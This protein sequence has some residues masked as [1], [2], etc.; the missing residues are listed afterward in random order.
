VAIVSER[1]S[2]VDRMIRILERVEYRRAESDGDKAAIFRMRHEAYTRD[3]KVAASPSRMFHD[4][5]DLS[6][7]AWL[8]GVFIDGELASSIR[9]HVSASLSAPLPA[10]AVF[11]DV[12]APH[13]SEGHC[14][15]DLTRH[16]NRLEFS[17]RI[18]EMPYVTLWPAL[19]AD[20][21]FDADYIV[22]AC[23]V[24]HAGA[25][26]RMAP[27]TQW[28]APREYPKLNRLMP[29]LAYD[30]RASREVIR[31]RY[32]FYRSTPEKRRKLFWNSSNALEDARITIR[33]EEAANAD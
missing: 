4:A 29:L 32:P 24:D 12:L 20:E 21:Y 7:N 2:F 11:S 18:P 8:I 19:L 13:L 6:P 26:R 27:I 28:A 10:T 16:V 14:L 30:C 3:G 9:V 5:L 23:R 31:A 1:T 15:I 25:F 33:R 17:R 22:G